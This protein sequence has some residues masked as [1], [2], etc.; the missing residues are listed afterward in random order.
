ME[1][2]ETSVV[3]ECVIALLL[4]CLAGIF[5]NRLYTKPTLTSLCIVC[6]VQNMYAG[7][8]VLTGVG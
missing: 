7:S 6:T 8:R 1:I 3:P 4:L 2:L 5:S